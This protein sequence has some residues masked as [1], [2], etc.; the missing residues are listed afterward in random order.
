MAGASSDGPSGCEVVL[1]PDDGVPQFCAVNLDHV[2]TVAKTK[3]GPFITALSDVHM[4]RV[5]SVLL[6]ALGFER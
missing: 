2:Q 6:F 1:T 3:V 5:Q 4:D